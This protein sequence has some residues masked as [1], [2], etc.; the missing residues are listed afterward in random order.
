MAER[1][2]INVYV[3]DDGTNY[4]VVKIFEDQNEVELKAQLRDLGYIS[5]FRKSYLTTKV[6]LCKEDERIE[7]CTDEYRSLKELEINEKS[8]IDIIPGR[9][10]K[11]NYY[12]G[13]SSGGRYLYG[14]PM[15]KSV[16]GA[17]NQAEGYSEED[18]LVSTGSIEELD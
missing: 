7:I 6:Y 8:F 3:S 11:V 9:E 10:P 15:A 1:K 2:T 13:S 16:E 12:F 5:S 18:S 4:D 17:I 14:C